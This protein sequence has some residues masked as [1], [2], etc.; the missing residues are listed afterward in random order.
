MKSLFIKL[1]ICTFVLLCTISIST[2]KIN[3]SYSPVIFSYTWTNRST[4]AIE[5]TDP[6]G[7]QLGSIG[8][9][10]L[11][12]GEEHY[13]RTSDGKVAYCL[14]V[15]KA[16][17]QN[18]NY[19]E[20][21]ETPEKLINAKKVLYWGYPNKSG[22]Y[23]GL[24]DL[25]LE[26]ATQYAIWAINGQVDLSYH[27]PLDYSDSSYT[28]PAQ[29]IYD[30]INELILKANTL[31]VQESTVDVYGKTQSFVNE[32][33][34][35]MTSGSL[36]LISNA[37]VNQIELS[38]KAIQL[39][40]YIEINDNNMGTSCNITNNDTFY[41]NF[42]AKNAR[43]S[44]NIEYTIIGND[45]K[46]FT[47]LYSHSQNSDEQ[48]MLIYGAGTNSNQVVYNGILNYD[49]CYGNISFQKYNELGLPM[50][51]VE[52]SVYTDPE[53]K[54]VL[55]T[56]DSTP[57]KIITDSTGKGSSNSIYIPN[58]ID[59]KLYVKETFINEGSDIYDINNSVF[60]ADILPGKTFA[61]NGG[62]TIV[63]NLKCG[64]I[65]IVKTSEDGEMIK[66]IGFHIYGTSLSG[67]TVDITTITN[68]TGT[69]LVSDV[70][71]GK[72]TI[73]EI[74]DTVNNLYFTAESQIIS[75]NYNKE[76]IANFYNTLKDVKVKVSKNVEQTASLS[77]SLI[78][79]IDRI[80]NLSNCDLDIF[81]LTDV[82]PPEVR[83][84]ELNTGTYNNNQDYSIWYKTN[85][86][87]DWKLWDDSV[88]T[89][90]SKHLKT[91]DLQLSDNEYITEFEFR[92]GKTV[93]S[94]KNETIP[95]YT[96][97][98]PKET[99]VN[100]VLINKI[101][102]YGSINDLFSKDNAET[103]TYILVPEMPT[104]PPTPEPTPTILS[105]NILTNPDTKDKTFILITSI[106]I[107]LIPVFS[108][109]N[110]YSS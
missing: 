68:A 93:I 109:K 45:S 101:E 106:F 87:E 21:D 26:Y 14:D 34:E 96:V 32:N 20:S 95:D 31:G 10:P 77:E 17:P 18:S 42:P 66:S 60:E 83:L 98:I 81:T 7:S 11:K 67:K 50:K 89:K 91:E 105:T 53:C 62:Q 58:G 13:H 47:Y 79:Y 38:E 107:L 3:G 84:I 16:N 36:Q 23:Y 61:L 22:S 108:L 12:D 78:Y 59:R 28:N 94:F 70:P 44:G 6:W 40:A 103:S 2:L 69:A 99:D 97:L 90:I 63:D 100:A 29:K 72:Y 52:F 35:E 27:L 37:E 110:E 73:E 55:T 75:V 92:F 88:N 5:P 71:L 19:F 74:P 76:S 30:V 104:P 48:D 85:I 54:N 57:Y 24:E 102:L 64:S 46:K 51:N 49:S 86:N 80:E 4:P 56:N 39:G 1:Y 65:K 43:E 8:F 15:L 9:Y 33:T 41:I 82:L 25:E